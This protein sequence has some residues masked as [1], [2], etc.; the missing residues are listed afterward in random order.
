MLEQMFLAAQKVF[1]CAEQVGFLLNI[2]KI[3]RYF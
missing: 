2:S 1:T 3:E